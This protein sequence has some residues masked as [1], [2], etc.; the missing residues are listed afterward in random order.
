[1]RAEIKAALASCG[2]EELAEILGEILQPSH[3][4]PL[5][6]SY[7]PD[8]YIEHFANAVHPVEQAYCAAFPAI[9]RSYAP[10][11]DVA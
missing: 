4:G 10:W 3:F 6:H 5:G 2:T 1:M 9:E 11:E 8:E 7:Q